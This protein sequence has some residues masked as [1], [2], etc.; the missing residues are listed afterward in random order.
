MVSS[1]ISICGYDLLGDAGSEGIRFAW[2][3]RGANQFLESAAF[4]QH[5]KNAQDNICG[6]TTSVSLGCI[7]RTIGCPCAF[8]R[9]GN[10]LPYADNLSA[11]DIAKQNVFMVLADINCSDHS[12]LSDLPREFAYMGQGEPGYSY[13]QLREAIK[14]TDYVMSQLGQ[15]VHRHLISTSGIPEMISAFKH[16]FESG[17]F[18]ERVTLHFSLHLAE[19]REMIMP[20]ERKY[21]FSQVLDIMSDVVTIT[22][23]KPC[24]GIMLFKDY[25]PKNTEFVYSNELIQVKNILSFIDPQKFRLSFCEFN[26]SSEVGDSGLYDSDT[27]NTVLEYALEHGYEAKLFSSFGKEKATACGMLG[28]KVA[29]KIASSKWINIEKETEALLFQA[30]KDLYNRK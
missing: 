24:V 28:G 7:L 8:C 30:Y 12:E 2:N 23:E 29:E 14:L 22:G 25:S 1:R 17:F 20:I 18:N 11:Y 3:Y 16:D 27:A 26:K 15:T 6:Y 19:Q 10:L 9:T 4:P 13:P 21:P 5:R